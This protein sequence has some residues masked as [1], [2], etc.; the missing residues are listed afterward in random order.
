MRINLSP[1]KHHIIDKEEDGVNHENSEIEE[2]QR[3]RSMSFEKDDKVEEPQT[4]V[5][6]T[7]GFETPECYANKQN[8]PL[9]PTSLN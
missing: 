6:H 4:P 9:P 5:T 7:T 1:A 8:N 3:L 2:L